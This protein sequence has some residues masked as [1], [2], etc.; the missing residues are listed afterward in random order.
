VKIS[1][2]QRQMARIYLERD[3]ARG[4]DATL[5]WLVEELGE[6][7][8]AVRKGS[9]AEVAHEAGDLLAWLA[10]LCNQLEVDLEEEAKRYSDGCPKCAGSPC[11]CP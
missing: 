8:K 3:R 5:A 7:S 11:R 6:L 4:V 1:E 2:F 9:K 10:S